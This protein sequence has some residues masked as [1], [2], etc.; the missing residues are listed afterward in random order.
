MAT[1]SHS[2]PLSSRANGCATLDYMVKSL[3]CCADHAPPDCRQDLQKMFF[4]KNHDIYIIKDL[5]II[6]RLN[7][8]I[9]HPNKWGS[10]TQPGGDQKFTHDQARALHHP[11]QA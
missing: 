4:K 11:S 10:S 9:H 8:N 5:P 3:P 7:T 2:P 1:P 6:K